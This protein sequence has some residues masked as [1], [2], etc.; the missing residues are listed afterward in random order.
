MNTSLFDDL[1]ESLF[2]RLIIIMGLGSPIAVIAMNSLTSTVSEAVLW[3][4]LLVESVLLIGAQFRKR[5][6]LGAMGIVFGGLILANT[7]AAG[8]TSA[9]PTLYIYSI[10]VFAGVFI[11]GI[12]A[13]LGMAVLCSTLIVGLP[14]QAGFLQ[15]LSPIA[16]LWIMW[17]FSVT[18]LQTVLRNF[19]QI[20]DYKRYAVR[21]MEDARASRA[22]LA[23]R[24]KALDEATQ[25]LEYTN[26]HLRDAR[27]AA[28]QARLLKAQFAA[29]VSHE[30]RTPINLIVGFSEMIATAPQAYGAPLPFAYRSDFNTIHRNARHLQSLIN[31]V[32]D[33]S[34]I[35]AGHM[36]VVTE[37]ISIQSVISVAVE[38]MRDQFRVKGLAL[39]TDL[40]DDLPL[41]WLD[42][43]RIRQVIINLLS[44]ALRFTD[45]GSVTVRAVL[46]DANVVVCVEDTGLGISQAE[47]ARVFDEFHQA[48]ASLARRHGGTGLGLALSRRFVE[49]HDGRMWLESEGVP[50]KGSRF[51][52]SLP[53]M[54]H[55]FPVAPMQ[56]PTYAARPTSDRTYLVID[57][58]PAVAA[59]FERYSQRNQV[60]TAGN[61]NDAA[62]LI[63]SAHPAAVVMDEGLAADL[64]GNQLGDAAL[65]T[66][67][68]PSGRRSM[69]TWGVTEYLVKPVSFETLRSVLR[70]LGRSIR[71]ILVIDDDREIVRL[72]YRMI[73]TMPEKYE[74]W[75]AYSG[76][77]G[78]D[79][80]RAQPPDA[81]VLDLL[82]P[83]VDGLTI[84]QLLK[85]DAR[86]TL[87]PVIVVS[88]RGAARVR[89]GSP[90]W[91]SI[92]SQKGGLSAA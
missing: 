66:C 3:L 86:L 90:Q 13:S 20:D 30:L 6:P 80:I 69:Q 59:L 18:I 43:V 41:L 91:N 7:L 87:I 78:L 72:F 29:N 40:P 89:D 33:V 16:T 76:T 82:M 27:R 56:T 22:I 11:T 28:E 10:L 19:S 57:D 79:L 25:N 37:E 63:R 8:V 92:N 64:D 55:T 58:D 71:T 65:I 9:P 35:E 73:Q 26:N 2:I 77:E 23:Q 62:H 74:I 52:F 49:L 85:T 24:T 5:S 46:D 48:D 70:K 45:T 47:V 31:D 53:V 21:Q 14:S 84:V 39:N 36:T 61:L 75:R 42:R 54:A 83:D 4:W 88:A 51:A 81:I 44:N 60:L 15:A 68:L 17:L 67:R 50:G 38:M 12:W 32:L 34:Q 1:R